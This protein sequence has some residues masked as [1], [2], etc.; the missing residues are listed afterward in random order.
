MQ[1]PLLKQSLLLPHQHCII[2]SPR[3]RR[4][5][6]LQQKR[7]RHLHAHLSTSCDPR[8]AISPSTKEAA[9]SSL[10]TMAWIAGLHAFHNLFFEI[11]LVILVPIGGLELGEGTQLRCVLP[12][13]FSL[14]NRVFSLFTCLPS[15]PCSLRLSVVLSLSPCAL[16]LTRA[17]SLRRTLSAVL[18][19]F[20]V[21]LVN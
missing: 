2:H 11:V 6:L 16:S 13:V 7:R 8:S 20:A 4:S 3:P 19:L 10:C 14:F 9:P 12:Q 21:L 1:H 15:S 17:L 5:Y 18:S